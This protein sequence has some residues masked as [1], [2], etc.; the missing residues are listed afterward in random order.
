M[1]LYQT[2]GRHWACGTLLSSLVSGG[3]TCCPVNPR[4]VEL[5]K[6]ERTMPAFPSS[7]ATCQWRCDE[8]NHLVL[9][10]KSGLMIEQMALQHELGRYVGFMSWLYEAL[11]SI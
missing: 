11:S 10:A 1:L 4:L 3:L 8:G 6:E 9:K 7:K 5:L 2:L